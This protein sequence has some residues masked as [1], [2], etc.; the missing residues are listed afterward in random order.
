MFDEDRKNFKHSYS[1]NPTLLFYLVIFM[2]LFC[3]RLFDMS[4]TYLATPN[5]SMESNI[6]VT[7]L[8]LGWFLFIVLNVLITLAI[9]LLFKFSWSRFS[10]RKAISNYFEPKPK[11]RNIPL[12]IGITLP[13]YVIITGYFQGLINILI[14]MEWILISFTNLLFLYPLIVGGIFGSISLYLTKK[15]L[16]ARKPRNVKKAHKV[17]IPKKIEEPEQG[18]NFF[19]IPM[20]NSPNSWIK[21]SEKDRS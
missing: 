12:E 19:I 8:G 21:I 6:M 14:Y 3:S 1:S 13:I 4:T 10:N 15:I 17:R 20:D 18:H 16:Y 7:T 9:F 11:S 5:L 2:L